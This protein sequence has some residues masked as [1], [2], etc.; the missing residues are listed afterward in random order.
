M[1]RQMRTREQI[2]VG[3]P[4]VQVSLDDVREVEPMQAIKIRQLDL[5]L[6]TLLDIRDLLKEPV[7]YSG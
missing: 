5:I 1:S 4:S 6:E 3:S 2:E 7:R